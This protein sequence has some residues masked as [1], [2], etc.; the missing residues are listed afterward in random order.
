WIRGE[1]RQITARESDG[2]PD[3]EDPSACSPTGGRA[4]NAIAAKLHFPRLLPSHL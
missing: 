1:T 2:G 3:C 4:A